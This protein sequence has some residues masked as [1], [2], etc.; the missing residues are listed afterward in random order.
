MIWFGWQRGAQQA[1]I[2]VLWLCGGIGRKISGLCWG[3][4]GR[5]LLINVVV[6]ILHYHFVAGISRLIIIIIIMQVELRCGRSIGNDLLGDSWHF[7]TKG[8]AA[9]V[10]SGES[11]KITGSA[12]AV[13]LGNAVGN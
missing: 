4:G 10:A 12:V 7:W 3:R 8:I 11:G 2:N 1:W 9:L 6:C 5:H 13:Q